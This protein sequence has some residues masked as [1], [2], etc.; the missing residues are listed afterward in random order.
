MSRVLAIDF[1][2]KKIGLA[3]SDELGISITNLPVMN[4]IEQTFWM[5]FFSLIKNYSVK[6]IVIGNP[7]QLDSKASVLENEINQF[8]THIAKKFKDLSIQMW[9]ERFTTQIA[10]QT[11]QSL[12]NSNKKN[13][14]SNTKKE[15]KKKKSTEDS[16]SAHI[17]LRS[18]LDSMTQ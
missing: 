4:Y 5:D 13:K 9:D 10:E 1:G 15:K 18:Y 8:K 12:I 11:M 7:L 2:R 16:L 6:T 14:S 17:L 3:I